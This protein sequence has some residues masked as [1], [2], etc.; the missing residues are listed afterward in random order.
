MVRIAKK[1]DKMVQKKNAVS[2]AGGAD[3]PAGRV[4]GGGRG[5]WTRW[6]PGRAVGLPARTGHLSRCEQPAWSA[7]ASWAGVLGEAARSG[8]PGRWDRCWVLGSF[9]L[10]VPRNKPNRGILSF[11]FNFVAVNPR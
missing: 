6:A 1:M 8:G 10:L 11:Y 2:A 7:P 5:E 4:K 3:R 9:S